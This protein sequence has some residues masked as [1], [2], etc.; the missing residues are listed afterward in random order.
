MKVAFVIPYFYPAWEYGGPPRVAYDLACAL[1]DRGHE[2]RVLT[3]DSGGAQRITE[4]DLDSI[5]KNERDGLRTFYSRN[6]SNYLAYRHRIFLPLELF[7]SMGQQLRGCDVVHVHEFRSTLAV[8]AYRATRQLGIPFV[9]SPHGGLRRLGKETLKA[10]YDRMW[11]NRILKDAAAVLSVSPV[12]EQE[13]LDA[14]VEPYRVRSLPNGVNGELFEQLP[15]RGSFRTRYGIHQ[16][17]IILFLARLNWTKGIDVL[18]SAFRKMRR[19]D[20]DVALVIAGPDDGYGDQARRLA[21]DLGSSVVLTGVLDERGKCEALV[22]SDL[23][24]IP[25]RHEMFPVTAL[26]ALMCGTPIL[27]SSVCGIPPSLDPSRGVARFRV[28]DAAD[29]AVRMSESL[30]SP[31]SAQER[32]NLGRERVV[33]RFLM[34]TIAGIAEGIYSSVT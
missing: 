34:P 26:E 8:P 21:A 12:E 30:G 18:I 4:A 27:A 3:T 28:G 2:V 13:S 33:E 10:V 16:P 23:L 25:S 24:V 7:R 19:E 17:R 22:D 1:V 32:A 6:L 9:L 15:D 5:R 14:G 29:L 11:G 20:P 31:S